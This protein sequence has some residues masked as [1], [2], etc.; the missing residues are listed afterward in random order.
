MV[1]YIIAVHCRPSLGEEPARFYTGISEA[2]AFRQRCAS[3]HIQATIEI[4]VLYGAI[5]NGH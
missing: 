4:G 3:V 2:C 5:G 1:A